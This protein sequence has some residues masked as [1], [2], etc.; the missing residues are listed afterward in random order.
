MPWELFGDRKFNYMLE[1]NI[2]R[3][4]SQVKCGCP[5]RCFLM[6]SKRRPDVM[7]AKTMVLRPTMMSSPVD[8]FD[9]VL[10]FLH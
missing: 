2:L 5:E 7:L 4:S 3:N 10:F 9:F 1:I 6:V 8:V